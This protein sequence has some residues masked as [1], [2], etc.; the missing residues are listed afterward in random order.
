MFL[1]GP[2]ANANSSGAAKV[3]IVGEPVLGEQLEDSQAALAAEVFLGLGEN[4]APA[5]RP[6]VVAG[7]P[8]PGA[9][10]GPLGVFRPPWQIAGG[11]DWDFRDHSDFNWDENRPPAESQLCI[12]CLLL[13]L[14][15]LAD[16]IRVLR[17]LADPGS[18]MEDGGCLYRQV[19]H[20]ISRAGFCQLVFPEVPRGH[21]QNLRSNRLAAKNVQW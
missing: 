19:F 12:S 15:W 1:A 4:T 2:F 17:L 9:R 11:D 6:A 18:T 13:F 7:Y 20:H 10:S 16:F 3:V 8:F 14:F 5:T 21:R